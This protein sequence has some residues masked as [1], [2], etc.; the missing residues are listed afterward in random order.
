MTK[1]KSDACSA[2]IAVALAGLSGSV[3]AAVVPL[4]PFDVTYMRLQTYMGQNNIPVLWYGTLSSPFGGL[5]FWPVPPASP[6]PGAPR[7]N[8]VAPPLAEAKRFHD[9]VLAAKLTGTKIFIGYELTT[10]QITDFGMDAP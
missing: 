8:S 4:A 6:S 3:H 1:H 9:L 5:S 7:C 10:C 2:L